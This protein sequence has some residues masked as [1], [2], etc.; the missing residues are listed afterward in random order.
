MIDC[1]ANSMRLVIS[2][3]ALFEHEVELLDCLIAFAILFLSKRKPAI[4]RVKPLSLP[5]I[6]K[7]AI[8][9]RAEFLS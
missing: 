5:R 8:Q 3:S 9:L 1:M 7:E 4:G 6:T 2:A